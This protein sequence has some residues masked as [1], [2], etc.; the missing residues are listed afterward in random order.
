[1]TSW[2]VRTVDSTQKSLRSHNCC[3]WTLLPFLSVSCPKRQRVLDGAGQRGWSPAQAWLLTHR[4]WRQ[5]DAGVH[6]S[7]KVPLPTLTSSLL[8]TAVSCFHPAKA[9]QGLV[10][11][12]PCN[13][14]REASSVPVGG[15]CLTYWFHQTTALTPSEVGV[16][17]L[18]TAFQ[19]FTNSRKTLK[20][21]S[22]TFDEIPWHYSRK[23][24]HPVRTWNEMNMKRTVGYA[25]LQSAFTNS[26][27]TAPLSLPSP[28]VWPWNERGKQDKGFVHQ[29]FE[30]CQQNSLT[31]CKVYE[32]Q[33]AFYQGVERFFGFPISG[34]RWIAWN[35]LY[36]MRVRFATECQLEIKR[37]LLW[38]ERFKYKNLKYKIQNDVQ[39]D[40]G[41]K[42]FTKG[43]FLNMLGMCLSCWFFFSPNLRILSL[44]CPTHQNQH[45]IFPEV[46]GELTGRGLWGS[47]EVFLEPCSRRK[48]QTQR[49]GCMLGG[50][51][52]VVGVALW[53]FPI[54]FCLS[55]IIYFHQVPPLEC[56]CY[57]IKLWPHNKDSLSF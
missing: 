24:Q 50:K 14:V 25:N 36:G 54:F 11:L 29:A 22:F 18:C 8:P 15:P 6:F 26:A 33:I 31:G 9:A 28:G 40:M 56:M 20:T 3:C 1:M 13:L 30:T 2:Q 51:Q 43:F 48:Y 41:N 12:Q 7:H 57:S 42:N 27:G 52:W 16:L 19:I 32:Y 37:K 38:E 49:A 4:G 45:K 17:A 55:M 21:S 5:G 35:A 23:H 53:F 44:N 34:P 10:P 39:T 47:M 46:K